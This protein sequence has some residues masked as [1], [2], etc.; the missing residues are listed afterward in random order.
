MQL[1]RRRKA[2]LADF[3]R[4]VKLRALRSACWYSWRVIAVGGS[5]ASRWETVAEGVKTLMD[6]NDYMRAKLEAQ[7]NRPSENLQRD[8][9][10]VQP[11]ESS[12][13]KSVKA[14]LDEINDIIAKVHD[15]AMFGM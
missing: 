9:V 6:E 11:A 12:P 3:N 7:E 14:T 2:F 5:A 13:V 10:R 1:L 15:H 8:L 4:R